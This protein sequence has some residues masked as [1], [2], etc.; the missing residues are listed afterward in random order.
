MQAG[1]GRKS[2][3]RKLPSGMKPQLKRARM[4][5]REDPKDPEDR[6]EVPVQKYDATDE[7]RFL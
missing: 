3:V 1:G 4:E 5:P 6:K 2:D 7:V